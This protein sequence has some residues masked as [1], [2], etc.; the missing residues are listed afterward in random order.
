MTSTNITF[1]GFSTFGVRLLRLLN[2]AMKISLVIFFETV[3][4]FPQ[5]T[6]LG[7]ITHI[8]VGIFW[9]IFKILQ[10]FVVFI[11]IYI[12]ICSLMSHYLHLV[13]QSS[14]RQWP[15]TSYHKDVSGASLQPITTEP[16]ANQNL[17]ARYGYIAAGYSKQMQAPE[18]H[19]N[20]SERYH[21][22][23]FHRKK[24]CCDICKSSRALQIGAR[25]VKVACFLC[26]VALSL[27][28][29]GSRGLNKQSLLVC[30]LMAGVSVQCFGFSNC[31][32]L[33]LYD[34][35]W[36]CLC[37]MWFSCQDGHGNQQS[38]V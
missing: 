36:F 4:F 17:Q 13:M 26:H 24:C 29:Q 3:D 14:V 6:W 12:H 30:S 15:F 31:Y 25:G 32:N 23:L 34:V 38:I 20:N 9:H 5:V 11:Q 28:R 10:R 27:Q 7:N 18:K 21:A 33:L 37:L 1:L 22:A 8:Y 2:S 16:F 19:Q 35:V